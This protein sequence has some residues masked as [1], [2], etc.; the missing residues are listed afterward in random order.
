MLH[1]HTGMLY[2]HDKLSGKLDQ[3]GTYTSSSSGLQSL[4]MSLEI[5]VN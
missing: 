5:C 1:Q 4:E 2:S 3:V